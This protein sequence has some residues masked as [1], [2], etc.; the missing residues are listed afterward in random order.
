[1]TE[2]DAR[3]DDRLDATRLCRAERHRYAHGDMAELERVLAATRGA[4]NYGAP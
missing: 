2:G 1:M 3:F 4:R